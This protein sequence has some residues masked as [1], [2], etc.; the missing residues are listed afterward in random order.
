MQPL[1]SAATYVMAAIV[2]IRLLG[3]R[4]MLKW[5]DRPI[6]AA[7]AENRAA[8]NGRHA[9]LVLAID[10]AGRHIPGGN[11]LARSLALTRML[12]TRG[13]AAETKIGVKT[14]NGFHAH[15]WVEVAGVPITPA[16]GRPLPSPAR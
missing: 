9:D 12:R 1:I 16:A 13:V 5:A 3:I 8:E 11:C 15:A 2:G 6:A 14:A 10:R 4:R 7:R